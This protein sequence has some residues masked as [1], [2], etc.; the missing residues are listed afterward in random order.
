MGFSTKRMRQKFKSTRI[1]SVRSPLWRK[2]G[3]VHGPTPRSYDYAFPPKMRRGALRS[4]LSERIREGKFMLLEGLDL[5]SHK[6]K[7]FLAILDGLKLEGQSVLV[8]DD[9]ENRNAELAMR[10][11]HRV[12]YLGPFRV[13]AYD[14]L[15]HRYLLITESAVATLQERLSA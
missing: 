13:H 9:R 5:P 2:G 3:T 1:G 7:E 6:T 8:V 11:L 14:V 12:D 15:A 4:V 10:N